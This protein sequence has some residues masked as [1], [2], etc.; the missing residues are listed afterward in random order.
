[1]SR[2]NFLGF[3]YLDDLVCIKRKIKTA[4]YSQA[5]CLAVILAASWPSNW[6]NPNCYQDQ[7]YF[8]TWDN[9]SFVTLLLWSSFDFAIPQ[10][11][12]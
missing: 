5:K 3:H 8:T 6:Q 4:L 9:I 1:M 11:A 2:M 10:Q 12:L 7:I